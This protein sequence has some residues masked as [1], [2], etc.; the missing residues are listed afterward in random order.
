MFS[1]PKSFTNPVGELQ[2]MMGNHDNIDKNGHAN[3]QNYLKPFNGGEAYPLHTYRVIK[4]YPFLAVSLLTT[5]S[6]GY[7]KS[8]QKWV[9]AHMA[10]AAKECPGKPIFVFTHVPPLHTCYATWAE[11]E[12]GD[13]WGT[14]KLN[15]IFNKYP[16]AVVFGGHSHYPIGDP[17]SIHQGA[18][19]K[20]KRKNYF[21]S[22]NVG[23]TT[24]SE[25]HQDGVSE[26]KHPTGHENV[27]EGVILTEL[28]NG[29]IEVRRYD[30][31]RNEEI[32]ASDRWVLEAPFDGSKFKYADIR[33]GDDNPND[34]PLRN[35]LPAPEFASSD[36][37]VQAESYTASF[38]IPQ[39]KDDECVFRY[40]VT[41]TEAQTGKVAAEGSVF[42]QFYL[43]SQIPATVE[44]TEQNLKPATAYRVEVKAYDSYDNASAP[45]TT[46]FTTKPDAGKKV[47]T[48][49]CRWTFDNPDNPLAPQ[50][51][52]AALEVVLIDQ[53]DRKVTLSEAGI[54]AIDVPSS[55]NRALRI[56]KHA[57]LRSRLGLTKE[58][59]DYTLM[60]DIRLKDTK[61]SN[62]IVQM[63]PRNEGDADIF[64]VDRRI[65]VGSLGHGGQLKP[66]KWYRIVFVN[67][68]GK[69]TSYMD[70]TYLKNSTNT[71]WNISPE[72]MFFFVDEDGERVRIDV[73]EI[74]FWNT[75]LDVSQVS[76]LGTVE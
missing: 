9:K 41:I 72:G 2:F 7:I 73:A 63:H 16:Q 26:G 40:C 11:W 69:F 61:T 46:T 6:D 53:L 33:D 32:G 67:K 14:D 59:K 43:N 36:V 50:D 15:A 42:S 34:R 38:I 45:I 35:G 71:R 51:G 5:S 17:R 19:P 75:P 76:Q 64:T 13:E 31:Y 60:I 55:Q 62:A 68:N 74:A 28:P 29:N 3:Y 49:D 37:R 52:S 48:A 66:G 58:T 24:Y 39:A 70:G 65:G 10:K 57:G 47:P 4:G 27:T 1:D 25:I 54:K 12:N 44:H 56:P 18:N 23:S 20:S 30:T 22:I 8:A 21:T